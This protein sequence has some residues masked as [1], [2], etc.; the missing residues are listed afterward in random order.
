MHL[1]AGATGFLGTE[2]CRRL[3]SRGEPMRALVRGSS[4][5]SRVETLRGMNAEVAIGDLRDQA[6]LAS[7]C[8]GV[9]TVISTANTVRSRISG[10]S[11]EATDAAGNANLID[12]AVAQG[13]ERF[14]FVS[15]SGHLPS[16]NPLV[17]SKRVTE[18]KLR[19]SSLDYVILRPSLFMEIWLG[20]HTGF[21]YPN[22]NVAI[23]GEGKNPISFISQDD[24][25]ELTVRVSLDRNVRNETIELGG[26]EA[27]APLDVVKIFESK[28]GRP[29][30]VQHVPEDAL[31]QM[32][33]NTD[34]PVAKTFASLQLAYSR[35]DAIPMQAVLD[36]FPMRMR[37]VEEYASGV[38]R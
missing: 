19:A 27:V 21:D 38:L 2:I 4:D 37:T 31:Q 5:A 25:A 15:V 3:G 14:I 1:I 7:A 18:A 10:D 28:A 16:D 20:P 24:V 8:A 12:A 33:E 22:A 11:F 6:S 17:I 9:D 23:F 13:V 32:A 35:G 30:A 36:R 34:D 26:P 29:F